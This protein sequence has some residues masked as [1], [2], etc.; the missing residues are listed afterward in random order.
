LRFSTLGYRELYC[1]GRL[2]C[3]MNILSRLPS[4]DTRTA[5]L[6]LTDTGDTALGK[7]V[8]V[9]AG[10]RAGA[11]GIHLLSV[12]ADAFAARVMLIRAAERSLDV[13][14]YIWHA[15]TTGLLLLEE[16]RNAAERGVRVRLLLDDN[17]IGRLDKT[18]A[19]LAR[20]PRIEI[21]LFN[22]YFF[23][24]FKPLG[25]LTDFRRLNH[26]MHNKS[27]TADSQATIVGGRNVGDEYFGNDPAMVF[28]DLDV[29]AVGPVARD[30]TTAF[31]A[32]WNSDSAYPVEAII[33]R[34]SPDDDRVLRAKLVEVRASANAQAYLAAVRETD[35]VEQ[36]RQGHVVL[37]W[38][39]VQVVYDSPAKALGRA[40]EDEL[41][42]PRF[43]RMVGK[44]ARD[45]D[46]VSAYFVPGQTGTD[47][48]TGYARQGVRLHIVTNSLAATD[49]A[50]VHAGY[51]KRRKALLQSGVSIGELKPNI[52]PRQGT[53]R[54]R[55]RTGPFGSSS[56]SLHA[57]TIVVDRCRVY[58][59]SC[60]LDQR[61]ILLNTEMGLVIDSPELG[62]TMSATLE[63][64][65]VDGTY[66]VTL[67][68]DSGALVWTEHT[69]AGVLRYHVEPKTEFLKRAG[70]RLLAWL[71]IEWLL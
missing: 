50:A 71:P 24:A 40:A 35:M 33:G 1:D 18:L 29:L 43:E 11:S 44:P 67:S 36:V 22:P 28:V 59:G 62:G 54:R 48:L 63:Q 58:I 26:R 6:G 10:A 52:A 32:Y 47:L 65:R 34:G 16:L 53:R 14:Y 66:E 3:E 68:T 46:L 39:P 21:R 64:Q 12:P 25:Y 15:D 38:V 49:V 42:L 37:E 19:T 7:I 2:E 17:G 57:K 61:S 45:L 51:A 4:L 41:L 60:N 23:R 55:V 9:P 69:D 27:L 20:H 70:A 56:A 31:D 8:D 13:Q 5:S 30:V